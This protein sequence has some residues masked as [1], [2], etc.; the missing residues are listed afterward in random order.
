MP[1]LWRYGRNFAPRGS[2]ASPEHQVALA[3]AVG[4]MQQSLLRLTASQRAIVTLFLEAE[5]KPADIAALM[6]KGSSAT[7]VALHRAL[8]RLRN[9]LRAAG[10]D[11]AAPA[12]EVAA[13]AEEEDA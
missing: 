7:R 1:R 6:G 3:E 8:E 4:V 9:D 12:D 5:M 13:M 10:I 11:A 2:R